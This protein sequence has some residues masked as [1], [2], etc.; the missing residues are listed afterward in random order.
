MTWT[1]PCHLARISFSAKH[2]QVGALYCRAVST[3]PHNRQNRIILYLFM[4]ELVSGQGVLERQCPKVL[5]S[6]GSD[7]VQLEVRHQEDLLAQFR[8][9]LV[10]RGGKCRSVSHSHLHFLLSTHLHPSDKHGQ[11]LRT[12][13]ASALRVGGMQYLSGLSEPG[14]Y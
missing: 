11:A 5:L 8:D 12:E 10:L 3:T 4:R 14:H 1:E 2:H 6:P 13:V 9:L 7:Q